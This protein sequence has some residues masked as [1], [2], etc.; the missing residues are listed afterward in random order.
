LEALVVNDRYRDTFN[1]FY[2]WVAQVCEGTATNDETAVARYWA[3]DG[4]MITNGRTVS[5]GI[6]ELKEHFDEF[7]EKYEW[8]RFLEPV[9]YSER[10]DDTVV[11]EYE[12]DA[13]SKEG[14]R[15]IVG[16]TGSLRHRY[17]VLAVFRMQDGR[18]REMR[19]VA[20]AEAA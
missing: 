10:G 12:I 4:E 11:I 9:E 6:A 18:V 16:D 13:Q 17:H 2:A 19:E 3:P 8:V 7:P 5:S 15:A 20:Y 1:E 14:K